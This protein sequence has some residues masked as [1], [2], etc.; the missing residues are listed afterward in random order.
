MEAT[1]DT[2]PAAEH[3][4]GWGTRAHVPQLTPPAALALCAEPVVLCWGCHWERRRQCCMPH[5]ALM[6]VQPRVTLG[7]GAATQCTPLDTPSCG[8]Q[9]QWSSAL[10]GEAHLPVGFATLYGMPSAFK[11]IEKN[12]WYKSENPHRSS[13]CILAIILHSQSTRLLQER[14]QNCEQF[15]PRAPSTLPLST[16]Q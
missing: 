8:L 7:H 6:E 4:N 16:N 10:G 5:L 12:S 1:E 15:K 3:A 11:R 14:L 9:L 13:Q 2:R